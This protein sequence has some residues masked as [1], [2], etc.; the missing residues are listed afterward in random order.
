VRSAHTLRRDWKFHAG[1]GLLTQREEN[2]RVRVKKTKKNN[3]EIMLFFKL[4]FIFIFVIGIIPII[5][6][7]LFFSA[8]VGSRDSISSEIT[9]IIIYW[10]VILFYIYIHI[11][12]INSIIS[13][14]NIIYTTCIVGVFDFILAAVFLVDYIDHKTGGLNITTLKEPEKIAGILMPA[15]TKL[16]LSRW[17]GNKNLFVHADFPKPVMWNNIPVTNM[18]WE[19]SSSD[20][21]R[22]TIGIERNLP[23]GNYV[24]I[25]GW[26]CKPDF[27][28]WDSAFPE[29]SRE[30]QHYQFYYC[31]L[32][33]GNV[34]H[35]P[36][37]RNQEL[38]LPWIE[39][40]V[41]RKN[42]YPKNWIVY[43]HNSSYSLD[44]LSDQEIPIRHAEF[45]VNDKTVR[46]FDI[47]F[48]YGKNERMLHPDCAIEA[49]YL[50]KMSW[51]N[52]Q[53]N[54]LAI[55]LTANGRNRFKLPASCFGKRVVEAT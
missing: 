12:L 8:L 4:F 18:S 33:D 21:Q 35:M 10:G 19:R 20:R 36:E 37:W 5:L 25:D 49:Q 54:I 34:L 11:W 2:M 32:T 9:D 31:N 46:S 48:N 23:N 27:I 29:D 13:R 3:R 52:E 42:P 50:Y 7:I 24:E 14:R 47:E 1:Y 40:S 30:A 6:F 45:N 26:Y 51:T 55:G 44:V 41:E 53:P 17:M 39:V 16:T 38:A 28:L 43:F 22:L 15:G